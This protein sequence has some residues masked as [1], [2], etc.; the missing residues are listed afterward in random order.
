MFN[1]GDAIDSF[2]KLPPTITLCGQ[3]FLSFRSEAVITAAAL[4]CFL[5]PAPLNPTASLEPI[6]QR[7]KG[8]DVE[9]ESSL[10][11]PFY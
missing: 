6:E 2:N 9:L 10:G 4:A 7:V 5:D 8:S 11:T 1:S 3:N